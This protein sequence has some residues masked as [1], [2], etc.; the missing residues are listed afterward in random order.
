MA[1]SA[2]PFEPFYTALK[3]L[4]HKVHKHTTTSVNLTLP[5]RPS[6]LSTDSN[7]YLDGA[8]GMLSDSTAFLYNNDAP[9]AVRV[10]EV[11]RGV[12]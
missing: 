10:A 6:D 3:N 4:R 7:P 12:D 1:P 11:K 5:I 2:V 9:W 8:I